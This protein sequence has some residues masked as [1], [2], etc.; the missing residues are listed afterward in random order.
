MPPVRTSGALLKFVKPLLHKGRYCL[1]G[2][3]LC[4]AQG[5]SKSAKRPPAFVHDVQRPHP[6]HT[7]SQEACCKVEPLQT[8]L[9]CYPSTNAANLATRL[10]TTPTKPA[11]NVKLPVVCGAAKLQWCTLSAPQP[12]YRPFPPPPTKSCMISTMLANHT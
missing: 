9:Q 1:P 6:R 5:T 8:P 10:T 4:K 3:P 7:C 2:Y 12:T 11:V